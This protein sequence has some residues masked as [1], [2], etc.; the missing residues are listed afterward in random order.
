[1]PS[2]MRLL[3][4]HWL[5]TTPLPPSPNTHTASTMSGVARR[6]MPQSGAITLQQKAA[7][8]AS[9]K[10]QEQQKQQSD[11]LGATAV[12][13]K[14]ITFRG[15]WNKVRVRMWVWRAGSG[16]WWRGLVLK[17]RGSPAWPRPLGLL[18]SAWLGGTKP[19]RGVAP[20]SS[21]EMCPDSLT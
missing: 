4:Y 16:W 14:A 5:L 6:K 7:L 8:A 12:F 18:S 10:K 2:I 21:E 3:P 19:G 1:M 15:N 17:A 9:T 11:E 13:Q 20:Q